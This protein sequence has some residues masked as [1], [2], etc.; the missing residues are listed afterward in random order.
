LNVPVHPFM[1]RWAVVEKSSGKFIGS[2]V[3]IPIPD[4]IEK[5]QLGYSFL[6]EHWGKGLATEVTMA[7]LNYFYNKTPL[8]EIYA[9]TETPNVA[10]GTNPVHAV[11]SITINP[12][13]WTREEILAP[14]SEGLGSYL[15][16]STGHFEK[17]PQLADAVINKS[18]GSLIT[19]TNLTGIIQPAGPGILHGYDYPLYYFNLRANAAERIEMWF[20]SKQS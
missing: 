19:T 16:D 1:G 11:D 17:V 18:K 13:S 3:I 7:G 14:A 8:L 12:I 5:T 6:P 20:L 4:D 10:P 15:P 9:V 2:F